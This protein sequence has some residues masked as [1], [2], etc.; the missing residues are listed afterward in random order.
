M[1]PHFTATKKLAEKKRTLNVRQKKN[2]FLIGKTTKRSA[3]IK[4]WP[5]P[6]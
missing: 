1:V 4:E 5:Q 2:G 3:P 6:N